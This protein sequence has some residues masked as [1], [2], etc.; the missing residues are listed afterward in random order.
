MRSMKGD[1]ALVFMLCMVEFMKENDALLILNQCL[2]RS[3]I[4]H[5]KCMTTLL[6]GFLSHS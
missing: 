3:E 6:E 2:S 4:V 5:F 1:C